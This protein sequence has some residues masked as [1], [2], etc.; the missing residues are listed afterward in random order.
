MDVQHIMEKHDG[1]TTTVRNPRE[2]LLDGLPVKERRLEL[3]GMSTAV[4]EGGEGSPIVLLHGP[5]EFAPKWLQVIPELVTTHRVV[6][7]DLPAHGASDAPEEPLDDDLMN[8]WLEEL[9]ESTCAE[10]PVIVGHGWSI[11]ARFALARGNRVARLVL[12]DTLGLAPFRPALKFAATMI[13]FQAH[14]TANTFNRFMRQCSWDL[15]GMQHRLEGRWDA[16]VE[17]VLELVHSPKSKVA[18]Q[19]MRSLG[20]P[21]IPPA[22]L[23]R[24][25]VPTA[26]IWGRE[27]RANRLHIAQEASARYGWPLYTIENAADDP[28]LDQPEAFVRSLRAAISQPTTISDETSR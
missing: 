18:G 26:L 21:R 28:P 19:M 7:P 8:D 13:A 2:R 10:P 1:R 5:G 14:P 24:I 6:A 4:L 25:P 15:D 16:V 20:L 11:A 12:V 9:I 3:A 22:D 17:Y 23:A 27:D